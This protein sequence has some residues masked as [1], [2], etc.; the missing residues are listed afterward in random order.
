M[1]IHVKEVSVHAT[2]CMN[3]KDTLVKE[4][5]DSRP[6]ITGLHLDRVSQVSVE[7]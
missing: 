6:H 7:R 1:I 4:M 3:P 5:I 2:M